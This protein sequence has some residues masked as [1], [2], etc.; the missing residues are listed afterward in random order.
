[1]KR[2]RF[3]MAEM[4]IKTVYAD[5][6]Q[7]VNSMRPPLRHHLAPRFRRFLPAA[8]ANTLSGGRIQSQRDGER[9]IPCLD[10][11][12]GKRTGEAGQRGPGN[13]DELV[14]MDAAVIF[15]LTCRAGKPYNVNKKMLFIGK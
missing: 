4:N 5:P 1:M 2:I 7:P 3:H 15:E 8:S 10:L 14:T 11:D 12:R 9:L 13:A 6:R